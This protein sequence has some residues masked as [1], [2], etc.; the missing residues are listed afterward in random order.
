VLNNDLLNF[1]NTA[2]AAVVALATIAGAL[3]LLDRV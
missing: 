3:P 1:I 2:V